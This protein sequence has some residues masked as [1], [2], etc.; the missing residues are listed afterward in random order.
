MDLKSIVPWGRSFEEYQKIFSLT[1]S[2]LQKNILGCGDGPASFNAELTA[3][4]GN[5]V[6]I[7]PVYQF[8]AASLKSRIAEV[9]DE[10]MP[11]M[12]ANKDQYIWDSIPSV[13][14]LGQTRM[15]AMKRFIDDYDKGKQ[16]GRYIN[17]SLPRLSFSDEQFDLALCSHYLFLYSGHVSLDVHI[18]SIKELCR[19]AREVRIY[20]LMALNGEIS[21]HLKKVIHTLKEAD[22]VSSLINVDYQFQRGA[23]QMLVIKRQT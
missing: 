9:Y 22:Y 4:G 16:S 6:S 21:P 19:V 23:T 5:I 17:E 18:A 15:S 11:Q 12:E 14:M 1:D 20:P 13:E 10:I 7:D 8:D 3:R 2:D